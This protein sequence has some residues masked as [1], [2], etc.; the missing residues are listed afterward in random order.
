M[1]RSS[2]GQD[3]DKKAA[4]KLRSEAAVMDPDTR[5]GAFTISNYTIPRTVDP[6]A[7]GST[8]ESS[9]LGYDASM[10]PLKIACK[11]SYR[12]KNSLCRQL[13]PAN[14]NNMDSLSTQMENLIIDSK[15]KTTWSKHFFRME[16]L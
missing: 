11:V 10:N 14:I 4:K 8:A 3:S 6:P 13:L 7:A 9:T 1:K 2:P 5:R 12:T 16:N 15:A